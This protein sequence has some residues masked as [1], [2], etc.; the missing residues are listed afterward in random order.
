[1]G[2][3]QRPQVVPILPCSS[4]CD[5]L[6]QSVPPPL[7]RN[8]ELARPPD[9]LAGDDALKA[10]G[11]ILAEENRAMNIVARFGGDESMSVLSESALDGALTYVT[12]V[13][14]RLAED[15]ILGP[16]RITASTGLAAFNP[17]T[18]NTVEDIIQAADTELYKKKGTRS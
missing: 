16:A 14:K 9:V 12:S 10:F 18:M 17:D 2:S 3:W 1:V 11:Q 8:I 15:P 4:V 5:L 7:G 13:E 6:C